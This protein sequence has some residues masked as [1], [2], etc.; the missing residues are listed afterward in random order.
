MFGLHERYI[1]SRKEKAQRSKEALCSRSNISYCWEKV[2]QVLNLFDIL[3]S[4]NDYIRWLSLRNLFILINLISIFHISLVVNE[5][6]KFCFSQAYNHHRLL[7]SHN[8][9]SGETYI[10]ID[11]RRNR[12]MI[13]ACW[14]Y[15][16]GIRPANMN[17]LMSTTDVKIFFRFGSVDWF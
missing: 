7:F 1:Y 11:T 15:R 5:I 9:T 13:Y 14:R 16:T 2:L 12:S 8:F 17:H 6:L 4:R 10:Q 3:E